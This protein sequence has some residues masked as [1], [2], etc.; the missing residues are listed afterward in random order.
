MRARAAE[1]DAVTR[2]DDIRCEVGGPPCGDPSVVF[3]ASAFITKGTTNPNKKQIIST[4][5][6]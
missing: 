4:S 5:K 2:G 6:V 1:I 3:Q